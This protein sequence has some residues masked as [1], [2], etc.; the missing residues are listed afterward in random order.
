M[1]GV[2]AWCDAQQQLVGAT[3]AE[4]GLGPSWRVELGA[5]T[6]GDLCLC[7]I[8]IW[9][10]DDM[11]IQVCGLTPEGYLATCCYSVACFIKKDSG[12]SKR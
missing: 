6:L 2:G 12:C 9:F 4:E 7:C 10:S 3:G 1:H 11:H 5:F 8:Y